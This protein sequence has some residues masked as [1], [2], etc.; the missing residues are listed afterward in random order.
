VG[1]TALDAPEKLRAATPAQLEESLLRDSR[2]GSAD[3]SPPGE[4]RRSRLQEAT[5]K[6][7]AAAAITLQAHARGRAG[8][9][10]YAWRCASADLEYD[11]ATYLQAVWRGHCTRRAAPAANAAG[12]ASHGLEPRS[13]PHTGGMPSPGHSHVLPQPNWP[14]PSGQPLSPR[15]L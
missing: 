1:F 12:S 13:L 4:A 5:D 15:S 7:R 2:G 8:R 3:P 10:E 9:I 11:A 6:V 14:R